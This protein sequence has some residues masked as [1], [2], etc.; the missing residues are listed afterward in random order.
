[1]IVNGITTSA[2]LV[3]T[4][5]KG[6]VNKFVRVYIEECWSSLIVYNTHFIRSSELETNDLPVLL[7]KRFI[8]Q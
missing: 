8:S 6:L 7:C 1:M 3:I 5:N 4:D 2:T